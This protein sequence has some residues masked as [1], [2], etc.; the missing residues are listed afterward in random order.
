M[1][2][3]HAILAQYCSARNQS[4]GSKGGH[5]QRMRCNPPVERSNCNKLEMSQT[6]LINA[7][8]TNKS[9]NT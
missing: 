4:N 7:F 5:K 1:S 8:S 6:S 2:I 3:I 9:K